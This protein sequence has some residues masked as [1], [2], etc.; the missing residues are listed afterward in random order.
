YA[1][2]LDAESSSE[3]VARSIAAIDQRAAARRAELQ[4]QMAKT[5]AALRARTRDAS[6]EDPQVRLSR[7]QV[8]LSRLEDERKSEIALAAGEQ[9]EAGIF[10][11][12]GAPPEVAT[13]EDHVFGAIKVA[14]AEKI[15]ESA[16]G[17]A[18]SGGVRARV[19]ALVRHE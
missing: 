3:V 14:I 11:S 5:Q 2:R 12:Y 13:F 6:G 16:R 8:E 19:D 1:K 15:N 10:I 17:T 7:L 18:R 4:Q 9:L